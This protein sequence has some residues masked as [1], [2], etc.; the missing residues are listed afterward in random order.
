[1][2]GWNNGIQSVSENGRQNRFIRIVHELYKIDKFSKQIKNVFDTHNEVSTPIRSLVRSGLVSGV[3]SDSQ[4][5]F[6]ERGS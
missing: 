2:S 4:R 3:S 5:T 1:M 6:S